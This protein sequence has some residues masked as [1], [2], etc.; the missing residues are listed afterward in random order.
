MARASHIPVE[1]LFL[2]MFMERIRGVYKDYKKGV[3]SAFMLVWGR[4]ALG[5]P[6]AAEDS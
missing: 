5:V 4:V 2:E 6:N 1:N 3:T